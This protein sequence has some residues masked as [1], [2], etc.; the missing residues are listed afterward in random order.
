MSQRRS[1]KGKRAN[2]ASVNSSSLSP[3]L[4]SLSEMFPDWGTDDL[5]TLLTEHQNDVEIVIDLIVNNK[6]AKWEPIKRDSRPKKRDDTN[7][8]ASS[9]IHT[10]TSQHHEPI[11][12]ANK[13]SKE[14]VKPDKKREKKVSQIHKK[15]TSSSSSQ[16]TNSKQAAQRV[17]PSL[18]KAERANT[19]TKKVSNSWAAALSQD[20]K[21]HVKPSSSSEPKV[22]DE[23]KVK[24]D[25]VGEGEE[26]AAFHD[27]PEARIQQTSIENLDKEDSRSQ[28][29]VQ[30]TSWASAIKPKAKTAKHAPS[31]TFSHDQ[32]IE[33]PDIED[34]VLARTETKTSIEQSIPDVSNVPQSIQTAQLP[35]SIVKESEVVL[36]Q[37]VSNIGVTFG[38][39]SLS[40]GDFSVEGGERQQRTTK[41]P[42]SAPAISNQTADSTYHH[43]GAD[44]N[45]YNQSQE[46]T[47][48]QPVQ[49]TQQAQQPR[50]PQQEQQEQ[51]QQQ[52]KP[53]QPPQEAYLARQ[54]APQVPEYYNQFQQIQQLY[55]QL[56]GAGTLPGQYGYPGYD[57][58]GAF[59]QA[60][61]GSMSPA[62]YHNSIGNT[63]QVKN[64]SQSGSTNADIGLSPLV[65]GSNVAQ[66]HLQSSQLSHQAPGSA[67]F[68]FPNYY[69]NYFN[70]PY[71][72]NGAGVTNAAGGF[73]MQQQVSDTS[74]GGHHSGGGEGESSQSQD[75]QAVQS[76]NQY[77]GQY[78]G[79][80]NQ[81]GSRGGMPLYPSSQPHPLG[82]AQVGEGDKQHNQHSHTQHPP[83]Q[84]QSQQGQPRPQGAQSQVGP[85]PNTLPGFPQQMPQYANYQQYH[86]YGNFQDNNQYRQWY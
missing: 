31:E 27:Q 41:P 13:Y 62:Y 6:V 81:Y 45:T 73:G 75:P 72:G 34:D 69:Y 17:N 49:R 46:T 77:Y 84:P 14:K 30:Q 3:Q 79:T 51:Q 48:S 66:Q 19:D 74:S 52:T 82:V 35:A 64:G 7:D 42:S 85:G 44:L 38:S 12:R 22:T 39:L 71:Y 4:Q 80:P 10:S 54:G 83:Q 68:G 9:L 26:S 65:Q 15:E 57:Y 25:G 29:D 78:Y 59:G 16:A 47:D 23:E 18:M 28:S 43:P 63:S 61:L 76:M 70:N 50:E 20:T 58:T 5:S 86:Q 32:R 1:Y 40:G 24:E 55:P 21:P 53:V 60:G 8:H 37:E 11:S 36:P 56:A 67:P 33:A 2:G